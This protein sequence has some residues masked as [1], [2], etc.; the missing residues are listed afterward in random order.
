MSV[1]EIWGEGAWQ[2][3]ACGGRHGLVF[4]V[5]AVE[6]RAGRNGGVVERWCLVFWAG[7]VCTEDR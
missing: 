2:W 6:E 1:V 5:G 3:L 7:C 4:L